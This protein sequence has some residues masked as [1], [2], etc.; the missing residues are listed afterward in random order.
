MRAGPR[1]HRSLGEI[2]ENRGY[3]EGGESCGS[4]RIEC[5]WNESHSESDGSVEWLMSVKYCTDPPF[6][7][8]SIQQSNRNLSRKPR[9]KQGPHIRRINGIHERKC[10]YGI[11]SQ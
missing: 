2:E 4:R 9:N 3:S 1:N 7:R 8:F 10:R 11:S 5:G 6:N